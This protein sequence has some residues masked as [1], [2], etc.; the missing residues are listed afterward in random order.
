MG[1]ET[2][3]LQDWKKFM[4]ASLLVAG[5]SILWNMFLVFDAPFFIVW[6]NA[7]EKIFSFTVCG[8]LFSFIYPNILHLNNVWRIILF[9]LTVSVFITVLEILTGALDFASFIPSIMTRTFGA[10]IGIT[11]ANLFYGG[12]K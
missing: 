9:G 5:I 6:V 2:T 10:I 3:I 1:R 8:L 12:F 4:L 7:M 11:I